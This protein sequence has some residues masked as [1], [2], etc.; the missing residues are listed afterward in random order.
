MAKLCITGCG[1]SGTKYITKVLNALGV[2]VKHEAMGKD[3][4]VSGTM[5]CKPE[6]G[7]QG[8]PWP[9]EGFDTI[10][11]QVRD[12]LKVIS[13]NTTA[14]RKGLVWLEQ[15]IPIKADMPPLERS[16]KY[17]YYWNLIAEN[18]TD[19]RYRIEDLP[20]IIDEF[21]KWTGAKNNIKALNEIPRNINKRKHTT[22]TWEDI[23]LAIENED[24]YNKMRKMETRYGY[25]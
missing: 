4:I 14:R 6:I 15:Y 10:L 1:R 23:E 17:W 22:Y 3:G 24:L 19:R 5:A 21:C 7:F 2:K 25:L 18:L 8:P 9:K 20:Q 11:H 16:A 13:S 12:P